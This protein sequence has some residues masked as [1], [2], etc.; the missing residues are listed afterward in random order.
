LSSPATRKRSP[1]LRRTSLA[2]S[3]LALGLLSPVP[4]LAETRDEASSGATPTGAAASRF[5][6]PVEDHQ[7]W[8][9]QLRLGGAVLEN[10]LLAIEEG[11]EILLPIDALADALGLAVEVDAERAR[12]EGWIVREG[13]TFS[14]DLGASEVHVDGRDY[15]AD[16]AHVLIWSG[17]VYVDAAALSRWWPVDL[18]VDSRAMR[19]EVSPRETLPVERRLARE[20]LHRRLG[21]RETEAPG[22][23]SQRAYAWWS[24]PAIDMSLSSRVLRPTVGG[25]HEWERSYDVATAGDLFQLQSETLL[26][27]IQGEYG[28]LRAR[29]GRRDLDGRLGGG[30]QA[31]DFWMGDVTTP[32]L[33]QLSQAR[34]GRGIQIS[35][36][37]IDTYT[38]LGRLALEGDLRPGWD[39][40]LYRD[41]VLLDFQSSNAELRYRFEDVPT[42]PGLNVLRLVFHGPRGEL[43][44]EERQIWMNGG[45][46]PAGE[47][48]YRFSFNQHDE[49]LFYFGDLG[50]EEQL[51]GEPRGIAELEHGFGDDFTLA[52]AGASLPL[53][54]GQRQYGS[55]TARGRLLGSFLR[56]DALR[57]NDGGWATGAAW[58]SR[59]YGVTLGLSHHEYRDFL[60]ERNR[61]LGGDELLGYTEASLDGRVADFVQPFQYRLAIGNSRLEDGRGDTD[62][63]LRLS[64]WLR[65]VWLTHTLRIQLDRGDGLDSRIVD[66][67]LLGSYRRGPLGLRG[68]LTYSTDSGDLTAAELV[69]DWT[70]LPLTTTRLGIVHSFEDSTSVIA[71]ASRLFGAAV[72]SAHI[73]VDRDGLLQ[74]GIGIS[75]GFTPDPYA[76]SPRAQGPGATRAGAVGARAFLDRNANG[77]LDPGEAP[78]PHVGFSARG[79]R[80]AR[81]GEDGTALLTDLPVDQRLAIGLDESTLDDPHWISPREDER[82]VLRPG[83]PVK[84]DFPVIPVGEIDG[85]VRRRQGQS[86]SPLAGI[87]V[88]LV[89]LEGRVVQSARSEI[90][91]F[92][93][94]EQIVVGAYRLRVD[95]DQARRFGLIPPDER[96]VEI[97]GAGDIRTGV[98]LELR[99]ASSSVTR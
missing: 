15:D 30:L 86:T 91:G 25:S 79:A 56:L 58:Q 55:I 95:P 78:L 27:G 81:T 7:L 85:F 22:S 52:L 33:S 66:G 45:L 5:R 60:S 90:D 59:V 14:L 6:R 28:R 35:N 36:F 87:S 42:V 73:E 83:A 64:T 72:L 67:E 71:S 12:A 1:G 57:A 41:N 75:F 74:A 2:A 94:L 69:G 62:G 19:V 17:D 32:A 68:R 51:R 97:R 37:P 61:E 50:G 80:N 26:T 34:G 44:E 48:R 18:A 10:G 16:H 88:Q 21:L 29:A 38:E 89:D 20:R 13:R 54:D 43:R 53:L 40:E 98:G 99:A 8:I 65:P 39:V 82:L 63:L 24:L 96:P 3:I 84:L 31:V 92:F 11:G 9:L 76:G 70:P 77:T 47:T 49:D 46:A 93:L 4:G 23:A